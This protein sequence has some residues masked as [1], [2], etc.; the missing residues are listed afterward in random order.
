MYLPPASK[1]LCSNYAW[2][3]AATEDRI[4]VLRGQPDHDNVKIDQIRIHARC[5]EIDGNLLEAAK[6]RRLLEALV[7]YHR[8]HYVIR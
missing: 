8:L 2:Y 3:R 7:Y 5:L 4:A 6:D 1:A